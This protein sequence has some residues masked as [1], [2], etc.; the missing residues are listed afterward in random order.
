MS[1]DKCNVSRRAKIF[2][3]DIK[4]KIQKYFS[5]QTPV[6]LKFKKIFGT[7]TCTITART[8]FFPPILVK[9]RSKRFVSYDH[10]Y[11]KRSK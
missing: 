10:I 3:G 6:K 2:F 4:K 7:N 1:L 5:G 11:T 8:Y 9:L